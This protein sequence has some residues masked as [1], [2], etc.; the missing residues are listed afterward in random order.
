MMATIAEVS[1]AI[2]VAGHAHPSPGDRMA[3]ADQE[4]DRSGPGSHPADPMHLGRRPDVEPGAGPRGAGG[5]PIADPAQSAV[6]SRSLRSPSRLPG[7]RVGT[8]AAC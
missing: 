5:E 2:I 3:Q 6:H 8:A 4:S 7:A 1:T